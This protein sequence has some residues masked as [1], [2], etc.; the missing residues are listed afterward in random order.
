MKSTQT[1]TIICLLL[2]A[3]ILHAESRKW[4]DTTGSFSVDAEMTTYKSGIVS[5]KKTDGRVVQVPLTKLS[6]K[7][8][9][10]VTQELRRRKEAA[11]T[12]TA[13]E[14]TTTS[15][16]WAQW[17]GPDRN[18]KSKETGLLD[19]WP[20]GGPKL[21]WSSKGLGEGYASVS[22]SD[23]KI[24]TMGKLR[25][26]T[27]LIALDENN[28]DVLWTTPAGGGGAPNCTPTVDKGRVYGISHGGDLTCASTADGKV[29][30]RK[31][32]GSDFGGKMMSS[33]GYSE[34]PLVDGDRLICTP[35]GS[36]AMLVA[37]DKTTGRPIWT[38]PFPGN[39][40]NKGKDGAGYSSIVIGEGAGVKQYVQLVGRGV[41]GV[42]A[43]TGRMLWSYNQVANGT[44]N[45][46]TPIVSGDFIFCS[47]GYND[48]GSALLRLK[49]SPNGISVQT[50]YT[51]TS[52]QLQNHHGGIIAHKNHLYLGHGHNKGFPA[53]VDLNTG[54]PTWGPLRGPGSGS[55]A[56]TYADG[57]LYFRYENGIMALVEANPKQ[58][59]LKGTFQIAS[60]NGK[61]W[62]H[63][64]ISNG[65]L[66]LRDQNELH[67]YEIK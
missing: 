54:R 16:E 18:G 13:S 20:E 61:S 23:G 2:C 19:S 59:N 35:G 4:T 32:F 21:L 5:L 26:Q 36:R 58:Y 3:T 12:P 29:E 7:D 64:V 34:S 60:K 10:F 11:S 42:D 31:N 66:Y 40:G 52:Q 38:T 65:K 53:C 6:A 67:C 44:A 51:Y 56:V 57:H 62:P 27:H 55:A 14:Q 30:W 25:G 41:I 28:G 15:T 45:V 1:L 24:Y 47:S 9:A 17:R 33:W 49:K 39:V 43:K 22:I 46:P 50:I 8:R 63:P 37:L 48:G